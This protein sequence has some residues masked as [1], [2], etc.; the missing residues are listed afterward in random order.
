MAASVAKAGYGTRILYLDSQTTTPA[1]LAAWKSV[2][3]V[4][5]KKIAEIQEIELPGSESQDIDVT[6][7]L[8]PS[9]FREFI[10]ALKDPGSLSGTA[11]LLVSEYNTLLNTVSGL[12]CAWKIE[13]CSSG[14]ADDSGTADM[15]VYFMGHLS[16]GNASLPHDG[17]RSVPFTIKVDSAP[18]VDT[19]TALLVSAS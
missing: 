1:D 2:S 17:K 11:N 12:K 9:N 18:V 6:H 14:A 4:V 8:S 15:N 10:P 5:S 3:W 7:T 13:T 16:L 19:A